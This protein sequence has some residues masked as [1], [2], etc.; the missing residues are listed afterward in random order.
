MAGHI[1]NQM[2]LYPNRHRKDKLTCNEIGS[3]SALNC[4]IM[5]LSSSPTHLLTDF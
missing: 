5:Y 3:A 1:P 2:R 4:E